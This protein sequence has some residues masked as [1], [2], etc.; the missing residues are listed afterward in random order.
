RRVLFRSSVRTPPLVPAAQIAVR[1]RV[2]ASERPIS[3]LLLDEMFILQAGRTPHAI[4]IATPDLELTYD[5]VERRSRVLASRLLELGIARG[6]LVA[7]IM[8]KGWEQ[9]AAVIGILRAG[10]AYLP[11]DP[12]LPVER[13]HALLAH[14]EVSVV[15]T[16]RNLADA[17]SWP[18][19]VTCLVVDIADDARAAAP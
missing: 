17:L 7:I 13:L 10:A 5:D 9:V 12:T 8:D 3:D 6:A 2:N 1:R 18:A 4:A 15:M 14:G 16:R 11:I 19:G